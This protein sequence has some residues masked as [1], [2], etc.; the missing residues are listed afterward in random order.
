MGPK[1]ICDHWGLGLL[2][3]VA[4]SY[5]GPTAIAAYRP[6]QHFS[7]IRV[8][9]HFNSRFIGLVTTGLTRSLAGGRVNIEE[10]CYRP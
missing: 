9:Q 3:V 8:I 1:S 7:H 5:G 2:A 6:T 4:P 10:A